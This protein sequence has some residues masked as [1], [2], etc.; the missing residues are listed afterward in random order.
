MDEE[1]PSNPN[2]PPRQ[3]GKFKFLLIALGPIPVGLIF[4]T[5]KAFVDSSHGQDA[6][7]SDLVMMGIFTLICT[8]TGSIGLCGGFD[9]GNQPKAWIGGI[10]LGIIMFVVDVFITFFVGCALIASGH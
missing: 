2:P 8:L 3:S 1:A 7:K 5:S 4:F 10:A 9:G 6:L